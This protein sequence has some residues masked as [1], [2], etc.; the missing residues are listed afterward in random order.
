MKLLIT[1]GTVFVSRT[2]AEYFLAQGH[3]VYVLNRNTRPQVPG[4]HLIQGDRHDLKDCLKGYRF[5]AVV[6]T[7][8]TRRDVTELLEALG[9]YGTFLFISSSAVYPETTPQPFRERAAAGY[10]AIWQQ[11]GMDKAEAEQALQQRDPQVYI[12]RPPYL[13]GPGNNVYR[14]AFVFDCAMEDRPFYLPKDGS[15]KLQFFHVEDLCRLADRIIRTQPEDHV[16]NTGSESP[17]TV[18]EWVRLCYQAAGKEP[19]FVSV[20]TEAGQKQYFPFYD[21][22]T[23]WMYPARRNC[24]PTPFLWIRGSGKPLTGTRSTRMRSTASR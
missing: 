18:R 21:Y 14:E 22:D 6:D 7:G 4:V 24:C 3:E 9:D 8:Y 19:V 10:N 13:Y 20:H 1:G 16:F 12:L 23:G 5:D 11:Y 2:L 17:V 15:M